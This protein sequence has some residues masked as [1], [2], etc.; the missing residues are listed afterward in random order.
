MKILINIH[1]FFLSINEPIKGM[2]AEL[3]YETVA[4]YKFVLAM[5]NA[6][7]DDYM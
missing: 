3:F 6:V 7:C 4:K 1:K 5:E 2:N